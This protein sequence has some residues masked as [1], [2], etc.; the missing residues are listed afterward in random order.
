MKFFI[1][2]PNPHYEYLNFTHLGQVVL[3]Q[4]MRYWGNPTLSAWAPRTS[5]SGIN[6]DVTIDEGKQ[7]KINWQLN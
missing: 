7:L 1:G 2:G 6:F 3:G 4:W 5:D